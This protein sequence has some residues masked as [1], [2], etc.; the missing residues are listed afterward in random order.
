MNA[1]PEQQKPQV[2][3]IPVQLRKYSEQ[4]KLEVALIENIQR[5]D[6]NALEEAQAYYDFMGL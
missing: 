5:T 4:R 3:K 6:L 1:V 2:L